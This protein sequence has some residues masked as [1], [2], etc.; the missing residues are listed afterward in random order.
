MK[1][2]FGH[3]REQKFA[4]IHISFFFNARGSDVEKSTEGMYRHLLFRLLTDLPETQQAL[5]SF[6]IYEL[7]REPNFVWHIN[8]LERV[9]MAAIARLKQ[10][11][12]WIYIDALDEGNEQQV[13]DMVAFFTSC[14][15]TP[16]IK[17][18]VFFAS[19]RYPNIGAQKSLELD[20][21]R[22]DEHLRDIERYV[23]K[24][25][26]FGNNQSFQDIQKDIVDRSSGVFMWVILVIEKLN[27]E[28]DRGCT[29]SDLKKTMSHIPDDLGQLFQEILDQSNGDDEPSTQLCLQW[30]LYSERPLDREELYFAIHAGKDG[31]AV[32]PFWNYDDVTTEVMD[33]FILNSSKGLAELTQNG[34]VQFIHETIRD[35][36]FGD[37]AKYV[38]DTAKGPL[39][40]L[41]H[42]RLS[43]CCAACI[44]ATQRI[45]SEDPEGSFEFPFTGYALYRGLNHAN[46]SEAGGVSQAS[47][48]QNFN[49]QQWI[50]LNS[51]PQIHTWLDTKRLRDYIGSDDSDTHEWTSFDSIPSRD[52]LRYYDSDSSLLY[53]VTA[54]KLPSLI[55][56]VLR[57]GLYTDIDGEF[58][59]SPLRLALRTAHCDT[60]AA[61]PAPS[62]GVDGDVISPDQLELEPHRLIYDYNHGLSSSERVSVAEVICR[63]GQELSLL[64]LLRSERCE[65]T[66]RMRMSPLAFAAERGYE[67]LLRFFLAR[68]KVNP[69]SKDISGFTPLSRAA[70][71]GRDHFAKLVL[72]HKDVHIDGQCSN[73]QTALSHAAN[74][75]HDSIFKLLCG[76][77]ANVNLPDEK[78]LTPLMYAAK[79]GHERIVR[80]LIA[81]GKTNISS[82][83]HSG[84]TAL[85]YAV[86]NGHESV[87]NRLLPEMRTGVNLKGVA[88]GRTPLVLALRE[89]YWRI[90]CLIVEHPDV[91]TKICDRQ[92]RNAGSYASDED[93]LDSQY[94]LAGTYQAKGRMQEAIELLKI[95]VKVHMKVLP[96]DDAVCLASQ[97]KL[98]MAYRANRQV[99]EAV[100][101]LGPVV[102]LGHGN[103]WFESA[104]QALADMQAELA[105]ES[106][107]TMS[108]TSSESFVVSD[109]EDFYLE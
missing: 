29:V 47:F 103:K 65:P 62:Y 109:S 5:N 4:D 38:Q 64:T 45:I 40:G 54:K 42:D 85:A 90:A 77:D 79:A 66:A 10:R 11:R 93:A 74:G 72:Q 16:G 34:T 97:Y 81:H 6:P 108:T 71:A 20:M 70:Q 56:A 99:Q 1:F 41:V 22:E 59:T 60:V 51:S 39:V 25:S 28:Y 88:H 107:E 69:I 83:S 86:F 102:K 106:D 53:V 67:Q 84:F 2:I 92:G 96:S 104:E 3:A 17:L 13:R 37:G 101:W 35:Y 50:F 49:V 61:L 48:L 82:Q 9:L 44:S 73:G 78:G 31:D 58:D 91:D 14:L 57:L 12:L 100:D 46:A 32:V 75:G 27:K 80:C 98:A 24:K 63:T 76:S 36:L 95:V 43:Q 68:D 18:H 19:R 87:V 55:R 23:K 8:I 26:E 33:A 89:K 7:P 105:V 30:L 94:A 15:E 52:Y 21:D